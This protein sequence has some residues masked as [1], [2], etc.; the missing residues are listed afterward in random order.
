MTRIYGKSGNSLT[1]SRPVYANTGSRAVYAAATRS[2]T[3]QAMSLA[4]GSTP[5]MLNGA[6]APRIRAAHQ[7]YH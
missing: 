7:G 3:P 2:A 5:V 1:G 4:R 6:S